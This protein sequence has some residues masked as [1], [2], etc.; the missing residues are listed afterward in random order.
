MQAFADPSSIY[1][2]RFTKGQSLDLTEFKAF[3][4]DKY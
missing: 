4:E 1:T 2:L 3:A